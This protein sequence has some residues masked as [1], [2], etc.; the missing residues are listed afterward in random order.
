MAVVIDET[1]ISFSQLKSDIRA[2]IDSKPDSEKWRDFFDASTGQTVIELLAGVLTFSAYNNITARRETYLAYTKVRS[3]MV[4]IS[5][6]LGYSVYRGQ[7][8]HLTLNINPTS[9]LSISKFDVIG[10]VKDK[11]LVAAQAYTLQTN[12]PIAME[13]IVGDK[14]TESLVVASNALS[15]FRFTADKVSNDIRVLLNL[16][17]VPLSNLTLDLINDKYVAISN[18]LGSVDVMYLNTTSGAAYPY[19][20]LDSL[21]LEWVEY[22]NISFV[23][24]DVMFNYGTFEPAGV[25][26]LTANATSEAGASIKINAPLFGETQFVIRGR[27]DYMKIFKL[28]DLTFVDT[29]YRDVSSEVVELTYVRN[30]MS[31]LGSGEESIFITKLSD[32]RPMG[33]QPPTI[34]DPIKVDMTLGI[35]VVLS[36]TTTSIAT[37]QTATD[38]ILAKYSKVLQNTLDLDQIES[39]M[40]QN[41]YVKITRVVVNSFTFQAWQTS[42]AY[43]AGDNKQPSVSNGRYYTCIIAGVSGILEP[44]WST[45]NGSST[46]DGSVV[47]KCIDPADTLVRTHALSWDEYANLSS[48][49]STS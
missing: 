1:S 18:V 34:K 28:L 27:E 14:K 10:S 4:G 44:S 46:S 5:Q 9:S 45:I 12:V 41:S 20:T 7:N 35:N 38:A 8:T 31:L 13:A 39:D 40:N 36:D 24:T 26:T 16:V 23:D 17:E 22:S 25:V 33:L 37:V 3:S 11:D 47:W 19:A 43:V 49:V 21:V 32:Y 42:T 29:S 48:N 6:N 15:V 2:F 30:D